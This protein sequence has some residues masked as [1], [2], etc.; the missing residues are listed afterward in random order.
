MKIKIEPHEPDETKISYQYYILILTRK[1]NAQLTK[2]TKRNLIPRVLKCREKT[3]LE[4]VQW[5][6]NN[7][8]VNV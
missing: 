1:K 3:V 8:M 4:K 6:L 2:H 7:V 5:F